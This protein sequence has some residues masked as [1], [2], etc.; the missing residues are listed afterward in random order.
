[1]SSPNSFKAFS[2]SSFAF[3]GSRFNSPAPF[4]VA[5]S[6]IF[7][8]SSSTAALVSA[9]AKIADS[10]GI[11]TEKLGGLRYAADLAGT[12]NDQL[13]KNL[14]KM[15]KSIGEMIE[16]AGAGG[17]ALSKLGLNTRAFFDL[18]PDQQFS[19]IADKINDLSTS[20]EK[21]TTASDIF[22]RSGVQLLNTLSLGSEGLAASNC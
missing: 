22:G 2:A 20:A 19:K 5:P 1:M 21:A 9:T 3:V 13:D 12:S 11:A 10:I 7:F 14:V 17:D 18:T 4:P 16:G 8:A 15:T 6:A